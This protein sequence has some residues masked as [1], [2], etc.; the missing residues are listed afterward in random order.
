VGAN[1]GR[2]KV[3]PA[4][5]AIADYVASARLLG[6]VADYVVVNVSSPNTPGLRDLQ[7][8]EALAP[9]LTAV[10]AALDDAAGRS[11]PLLVKIA[12][13]LADADLDAVADAALGAGVQGI[14]ATNTTVSRHGLRSD[15]AEVAAAGEGGLS[16]APLARRSL[17]VLERLYARVGDRLVLVSAGGIETAEDAWRRIRAG[18]TLLQ[19]YT[20]FVYGGPR[21]PSRLQRDL[22]ALAQRDGFRSVADAV[23]S[24]AVRT[25]TA[26]GGSGGADLEARRS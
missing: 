1:I 4:G 15:P 19:A 21:W 18:A 5:E 16:G 8:V 6:P 10:R 7:A 22:A 20:G 24:G 3:V 13:D 25:A 12:P 14:I 2:T 26:G 9:L 23:G 11:V 17:E